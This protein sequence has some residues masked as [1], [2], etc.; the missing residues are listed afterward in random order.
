ME[1]QGRRRRPRRPRRRRRGGRRPGG[2]R[3]EEGQAEGGE[4]G[5]EESRRWRV[6]VPPHPARLLVW[7]LVHGCF[8]P[9]GGGARCRRLPA[10][11]L[12]TGRSGRW[13]NRLQCDTRRSIQRAH[14]YDPSQHRLHVS[15]PF[16]APGS[17]SLP[18][19]ALG[20]SRSPR[21]ARHAQVQQACTRGR[22]NSTHST[23]CS[24]VITPLSR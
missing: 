16:I 4:A 10:A 14:S 12:K 13:W 11:R 6:P 18:R 15:L 7:M 17:R 22:T 24:M 23:T 2:M 3:Q 9:P 1:Q 21:S 5:E 8:L 19:P 20:S